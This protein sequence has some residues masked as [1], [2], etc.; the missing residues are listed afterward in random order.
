VKQSHINDKMREILIDW[1]VDVSVKFRLL[2][3]T[4]FMAV[5]LVD[6]F[7]QREQVTRDR[8]QLL[9][10]TSLFIASKYEEIYPPHMKEYIAVCDRAT[11]SKQDML[12]MEAVV[13]LSL[14]FNLTDST[15][16]R[17][18]E[19]FG[20]VAGLESRAFM[21]ARYLTELALVDGVFLNVPNS[22][23][24]ASAVYLSNKV[25]KREE[26]SENLK[27]DTLLGLS[28]VRP[29]AKELYLLMCKSD[30]TGLSAVKRKF[31]SKNYLEIGKYRIEIKC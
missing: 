22:L 7:L 26:W 8:F 21:F 2:S 3:A 31:S 13:I 27:R 30:G 1:L 20:R 4:L 9:G 19:R 29:T 15:V 28:D 16:L 24:A 17:F 5:N 14:E 6:R 10:I 25:F 23:I 12:D 11:Y 18:L